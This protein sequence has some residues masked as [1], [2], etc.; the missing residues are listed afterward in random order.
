MQQTILIENVDTGL[1][2]EQIKLLDSLLHSMKRNDFSLPCQDRAL[3][4]VLNMLA[5][6]QEAE[7]TVLFVNHLPKGKHEEKEN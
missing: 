2:Q 7:Q 6:R 4:G 1:L 5:E 3:E